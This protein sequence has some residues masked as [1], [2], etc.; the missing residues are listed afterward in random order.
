MNKP[1]SSTS[2]QSGCW[3]LAA[4][5]GLVV[6][7][8]CLFLIDMGIL[9]SI[10]MGAVVFIVVGLL[11]GW[12][13]CSE[14]KPLVQPNDTSAAPSAPEPAPVSEPAPA[15]APV[16]Q[17]PKAEAPEVEAVED[18]V[19]PEALSGARNGDADDLKMIKGVGPKLEIMLNE[20][21]F[22]HFDQIA[23]WSA[24][25]VAW[26]ND[27]LTGFKGRVSRDNW[28]EQARK[29]ASGQET[30]FSKRVSDGDVY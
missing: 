29:L 24:A 4:A 15:T 18:A 23:G 21:G 28:V 9:A 2:C 1:I 3:I 12:I 20:L 17:A 11:L 16:A 5:S 6:L 25:E 30:E 22:Y 13:F 7:A 14:L 8:V 10:F 27:N 19:R 26:V